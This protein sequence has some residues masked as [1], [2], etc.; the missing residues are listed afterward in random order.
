MK[1]A[2]LRG[3]STMQALERC[4]KL[5]AGT[6]RQLFIDCPATDHRILLVLNVIDKK[7]MDDGFMGISKLDYQTVRAF[8]IKARDQM[9][10]AAA[11]AE[12]REQSWSRWFYPEYSKIRKVRD[13][14]CQIATDHGSLKPS[15]SLQH[16]FFSMNGYFGYRDAYTSAHTF[17]T[18]GLFV[19][20]CR[21]AARLLE[22]KLHF[23]GALEDW[24]TNTIHG[25]N[26]CITG[27]SGEASVDYATRGVREPKMGDI[28]H[29]SKPDKTA[30]HVG[31][32]L[33]HQ[34]SSNGDWIWKTAEGGQSTGSICTVMYDHTLAFKDGKHWLGKRPVRKWI[35]LDLL[36]LALMKR[37]AP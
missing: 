17:S 11:K 36:A 1:I 34:R 21:A 13:R 9:T 8:L 4:N 18:C 26:P 33:S 37:P 25:T 6:R 5:D 15:E 16:S 28:F 27:P 14:F 32:I 35:D 24:Q 23:N 22:R 3:L 7:Y 2:E 12:A 29:I 30:D 19:R 10:N 31:I 20:A